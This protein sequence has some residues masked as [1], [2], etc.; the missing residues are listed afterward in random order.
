M[1]GNA[2]LNLA[3]VFRPDAGVT[4]FAA[5][6]VSG[7]RWSG[8]RMRVMARA[9]PKLVLAGT[10]ASAQ[11]Q[12]LGMTYNAKV[13]ILPVEDRHKIIESS[14]WLVIAFA[15]VELGDSRGT[16]QMALFTD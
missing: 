12:L 10:R 7:A 1:A 11:S 4:G 2:I 15:L 8:D 5:L 13:L 16:L 6:I 9:A 3:G 14:A